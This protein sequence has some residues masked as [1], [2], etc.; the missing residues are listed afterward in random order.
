MV[1]KKG[2]SMKAL[3]FAGHKVRRAITKTEKDSEGRW[4]TVDLGEEVVTFDVFVTGA[5]FDG[6]ARTA[7]KN[8]SGKCVDGCIEVVVTKRV[9]GV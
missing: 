6:M 1:E 7:A 2:I 3:L 5:G 9:R 4:Q 8:K